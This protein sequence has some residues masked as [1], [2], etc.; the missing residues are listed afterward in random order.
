MHLISVG[1]KDQGDQRV[2]MVAVKDMYYQNCK[3]YFSALMLSF[4][5]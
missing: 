2:G 3:L 4:M 1:S 5:S